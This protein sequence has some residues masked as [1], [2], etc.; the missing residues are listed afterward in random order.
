VSQVEDPK[1]TWDD[2]RAHVWHQPGEHGAAWTHDDPGACCT[3]SKLAH[4]TWSTAV[5]CERTSQLTAW[6]KRLR[7]AR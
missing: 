3:T 1:P 5:N 2:A 6:R 4:R 7:A